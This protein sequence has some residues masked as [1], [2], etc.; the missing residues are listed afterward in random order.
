MPMVA[1]NVRC[2]PAVDLATLAVT[3]YDGAAL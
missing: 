3:S 1:V 2:V